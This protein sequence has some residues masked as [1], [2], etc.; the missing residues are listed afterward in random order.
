MSAAPLLIAVILAFLWL[1]RFRLKE[2][3]LRA[4]GLFFLI[5]LIFSSNKEYYGIR[6]EL[7]ESTFSPLSLVR[8]VL[9]GWLCWQA[10]KLETPA[11]YRFNLPLTAV[12]TLLILVM[13]L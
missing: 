2:R 6:A 4:Y 8:W 13:L 11:G 5:L 3:F 1:F 10:W 9:L 12:A 7:T